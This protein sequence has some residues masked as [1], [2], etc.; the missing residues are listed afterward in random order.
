M[1][2]DQAHTTA[3]D[4]DLISSTSTA[5]SSYTNI[6]GQGTLASPLGSM[7]GDSY[8]VGM[9]YIKY[10]HSGGATSLSDKHTFDIHGVYV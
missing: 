2:D 8:V 1:W 9:A 7:S 5:Q 3:T 10:G 6:I 4:I